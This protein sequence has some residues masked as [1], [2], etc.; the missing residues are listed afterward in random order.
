MDLNCFTNIVEKGH[1]SMYNVE[2][3]LVS[4]QRIEKLQVA[5]FNWLRIRLEVGQRSVYERFAIDWSYYEVM[6]RRIFFI[7][8]AKD[9]EI[10]QRSVYEGL[11]KR[12][13]CGRSLE[14]A[15][16]RWNCNLFIPNTNTT[17]P[18][19]PRKVLEMKWTVWYA[20]N[21]TEGKGSPFLKQAMPLWKQHISKT[22]FPKL[23]KSPSDQLVF[24]SPFLA[25]V[26]NGT[27]RGT[28]RGSQRVKIDV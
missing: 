5:F 25:W 28:P 7:I 13:N 16:G 23:C 26:S 9:L 11:I 2:S 8:S 18:N 12:R 1:S 24:C 19:S 27:S 14:G 21:K 6:W 10:G 17:R 20:S 15:G 3:I 4:L 22:G